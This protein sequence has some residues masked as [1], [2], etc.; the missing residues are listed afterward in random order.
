M[1][2]V[3]RFELTSDTEGGPERP[4]SDA[5]LQN[6]AE[7]ETSVWLRSESSPEGLVEDYD[8]AYVCE[9]GVGFLRGLG[10]DVERRPV[11]GDPGHCVITGHKSRR[12]LRRVVRAVSWVP[13]FGP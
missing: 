2:R 6:K 12:T 1:R 3:R 9:V 10:L 7:G 11:E 5:F 8:E 13:G 4:S